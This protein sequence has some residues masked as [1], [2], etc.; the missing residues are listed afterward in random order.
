MYKLPMPRVDKKRKLVCVYSSQLCMFEIRMITA[1]GKVSKMFAPEV[2]FTAEI[3]AAFRRFTVPFAQFR[4]VAGVQKSDYKSWNAYI[5][6]IWRRA[7][8]RK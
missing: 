4:A 7:T 2:A 3:R 8:S 1:K 5:E 6:G